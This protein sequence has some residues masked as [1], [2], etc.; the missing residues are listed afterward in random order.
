MNRSSLRILRAVG[1]NGEILLSEA[2]SLA[3][4]EHGDH[5]DQYPLAMLIEDDY[6][7]LTMTHEPPDS[8]ATMRE[9]R[10]RAT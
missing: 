3:H 9:H 1:K 7:G 5:R 6:L 4:A 10:K 2:L 8:Y